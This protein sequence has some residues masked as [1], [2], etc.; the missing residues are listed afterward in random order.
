MNKLIARFWIATIR[1][2]NSIVRRIALYSFVGGYLLI[3][4][5]IGGVLPLPIAFN[6]LLLYG[7]C[8][9]I[10]IWGFCVMRKNGLKKIQD[11]TL[12]EKAHLEMLKFIADRKHK[13]ST[14]DLIKLKENR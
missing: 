3:F 9:M 7:T 5:S 4:L 13:L 10:M 8:V 6:I 2:H 12:R 1:H 14:V 11:K